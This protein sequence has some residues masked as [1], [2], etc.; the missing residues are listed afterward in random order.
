MMI[1]LERYEHHYYIRIKKSR[2]LVLQIVAREIINDYD[3]VL[4]NV[5]ARDKL[6]E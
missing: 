2:P 5:S 1:S 6:I 4:D 3:G